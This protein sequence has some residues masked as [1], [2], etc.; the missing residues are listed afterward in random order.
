MVS[1]EPKLYVP[2][3]H[4]LESL[5]SLATC[6]CPLNYFHSVPLEL[7]PQ[8]RFLYANNIHHGASLAA[9]M[10]KNLPALQ[11]MQVRSVSWEDPLEKERA[12]DSSIL[13]W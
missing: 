5:T 11:E 4:K 2:Q 9:Q 3:I 10:V 6:T 8:F 13:A 1:V 7:F 12:T